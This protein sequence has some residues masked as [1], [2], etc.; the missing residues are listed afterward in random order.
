MASPNTLIGHSMTR[1]RSTKKIRNLTIHIENDQQ[2]ILPVSCP[3][4]KILQTKTCRRLIKIV[5]TG[6]II[7]L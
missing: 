1:S 5:L 7:V 3:V 2:N 6:K 4:V